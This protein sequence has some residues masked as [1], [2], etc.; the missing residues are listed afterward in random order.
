[1]L[2]QTPNTLTLSGVKT[3]HP[4]RHPIQ[5]SIDPISN[6]LV[7]QGYAIDKIPK[8]VAALN[9]TVQAVDQANR[10]LSESDKELLRWHQRLG[11]MAYARIRALMCFGVLGFTQSTCTLHTKTAQSRT[12]PLCAACQF[13]KQTCRIV[14][15]PQCTTAWVT[16]EHGVIA[17]G[18]CLPGQR[19]SVDHFVCSTHGRRFNTRGASSNENSMYAGG[20]LFYDHASRYINVRFQAHLNTHKTLQSKKKFE[21]RCRDFG[22]IIGLY[23]SNNGSSF[24][25]SD[26]TRHL[27]DFKQITSFAV[28]GAH[29]ANGAAEC[30]ICTITNMARTMMLHQGICWP[31]MADPQLWPMAVRHAVHVYNHVP[32]DDNGL[33]PH[34]LITCT[35]T[36]TKRL[37]DLHVWGC[38][39][40]VLHG[41]LADGKKIP[42]WQAMS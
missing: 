16:N 9:M 1:M 30:T 18:D 5:V 21:E 23:H 2:H 35:R 38:P 34:D 25:S 8:G 24:T 3:S 42:H 10:N 15:R 12:C 6:L 37:H 39:V 19:V 13:G 17:N 26:Y 20:C 14:P 40:Y 29:H 11:H 27:Q 22:V 41:D 7:A 33:S 28:V 36:P 32:C 31:E 4:P